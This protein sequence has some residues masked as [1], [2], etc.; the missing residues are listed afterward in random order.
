M[1]RLS[2]I[3]VLLAAAGCT[4]WTPLSVPKTMSW[5]PDAD[6]VVV[7]GPRAVPGS[8]TEQ[9]VCLAVTNETRRGVLTDYV[10]LV[11]AGVDLSEK[12]RGDVRVGDRVW[13]N[14]DWIASEGLRLVA[15]ELGLRRL[16]DR[17]RAAYAAL[18]SASS[19]AC[20]SGPAEA[21]G[22]SEPAPQPASLGWAP[23]DSGVENGV[24]WLML[25]GADG[26]EVVVHGEP[27]DLAGIARRLGGA[28]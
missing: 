16:G 28:H 17:E 18:A 4:G 13:A 2:L 21:P 19:D 3:L 23:V 20:G 15:R 10:R 11:V 1:R 27:G 22:A 25:R 7:S 5:T 6:G 26:R 24:D 12:L 14:G 9:E 8:S